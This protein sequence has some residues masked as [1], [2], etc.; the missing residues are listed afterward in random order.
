MSISKDVI[1]QCLIDT[2]TLTDYKLTKKE[3]A[4]STEKHKTTVSNEC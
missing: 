2:Y 1:K 4:I 3:V